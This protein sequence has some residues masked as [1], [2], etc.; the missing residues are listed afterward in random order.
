MKSVGGLFL[1][2]VVLMASSSQAGEPNTHSQN[3]TGWVKAGYNRLL[4]RSSE[5]GIQQL[6]ERCVQEKWDQAQVDS[7]LKSSDEY[8]RY[9]EQTC[10]M[11]IEDAKNRSLAG[12]STENTK[13]LIADC[14]SKDPL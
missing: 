14:V 5:S 10:Q 1:T 6:A 2:A 7:Y 13:A 3:C 4:N 12:A 11:M 9:H 8:K